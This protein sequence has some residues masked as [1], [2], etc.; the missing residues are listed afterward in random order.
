[1]EEN[2]MSATIRARLQ[3]RRTF[4]STAFGATGLMLLAACAPAA[5]PS[6]TSAP[7]GGAPKPAGGSPVPVGSPATAASPAPKPAGSPAASASPASAPLTKPPAVAGFPAKPVTIIVPFNPGGGFD[8]VARQ[9]ATPMQQQLGQPV[10]VQNVPGGGTRIGARQFQQAPADGHTLFFGTD[11]GLFADTLLTPGEGFDI[12]KWEWVAGIR[13]QPSAIFVNKDSPYKT[14]DD[15]SKADASGTRIRMGHNGLGGGYGLLQSVAAEA[16]GWKNAGLVGGFTGTAD[17]VPALVRGDLDVQVIAPVSS[18]NQFI[19]SGDIR[20]LVVLT[21]ERN[22]LIPDVPTARE[23]KLPNI[24]DL[25]AFGNLV[26]GFAAVPGTPADR[27]KVLEYATLQAMQDPGFQEW[28]KGAGVSTDLVSV[29]GERF[30]ELK[31]IE[32]GVYRKYE[33]VLRRTFPPS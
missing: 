2:L 3:S 28:A 11:S 7:A 18:V 30:R 33:P 19:R 10:V 12:S 9:I 4:L 27:M 21:P 23:A 29:T 17:I 32:Y 26:I 24:P 22:S 1:M 15:V 31:A 25:E 8:A 14:I 6:P 20:A 13:S 16:L 5:Q